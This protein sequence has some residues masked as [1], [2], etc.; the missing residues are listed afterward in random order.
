MSWPQTLHA[1]PLRPSLT[2]LLAR[3][4]LLPLAMAYDL[5]FWCPFFYL[6]AICQFIPEVNLFSSQ[7]ATTFGLTAWSGHAF[8]NPTQ[9]YTQSQSLYT[10]LWVCKCVFVCWRGREGGKEETRQGFAAIQRLSAF[11][12]PTRRRYE[13]TWNNFSLKLFVQLFEKGQMQQL[14]WS[15]LNV[16]AAETDRLAP[17]T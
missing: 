17:K 15:W 2:P 14:M 3:C 8:C 16:T 10:H 9:T 5:L 6:Y 11:K 7:D 12:D 13:D 1:P 4:P